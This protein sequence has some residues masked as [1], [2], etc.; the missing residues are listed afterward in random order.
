M[1]QSLEKHLTKHM[2]RTV[3]FLCHEV[4]T[5]LS[6]V[7][8]YVEMMLERMMGPIT[9]EQEKGLSVSVRS[10][11]RITLLIDEL[12]K[13]ALKADNKMT[14]H[15]EPV[16]LHDVIVECIETVAPGAKKRGIRLSFDTVTG[17]IVIPADKRK[18]FQVFTNLLSNAIKFN[19]RGGGVHVSLT[20]KG[21]E[22][23]IRIS[24]TGIGIPM[25]ERNKIFDRYYQTDM[26][27]VRQYGGF[28]IGLALTREII[29]LH[30]GQIHV[31]SAPGRGS[32]FEITLPLNRV[33]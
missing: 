10:I 31:E 21:T 14:L 23:V 19:R 30:G 4:R 17:H 1:H 28:G 6:S 25:E 9:P 16:C 11:D 22:V 20:G 32:T 24:D 12:L 29:G 15:P 3:A 2:A 5:P 26:S 13:S 8:G 7:R 27:S 18:I 33:V